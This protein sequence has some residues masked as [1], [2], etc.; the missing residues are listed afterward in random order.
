MLASKLRGVGVAQSVRMYSALHAC[1]GSES[2][3]QMP[4]IVLP[5][6]LPVERAYELAVAVV[7]ERLASADPA[8][9]DGSRLRIDPHRARTVALAVTHTHGSAL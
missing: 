7:P 2:A 9:D 5:Q 3:Q 1:L 6:R 4:N 8:A